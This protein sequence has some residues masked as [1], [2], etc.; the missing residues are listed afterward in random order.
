MQHYELI[1]HLITAFGGCPRLAVQNGCSLRY[2]SGQNASYEVDPACFLPLN[3]KSERTAIENYR[4]RISQIDDP[5]AI[6]I[7]ER[8]ILDEQNHIEIFNSFLSRI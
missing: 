3:I 1:G 4:E 7:L 2:W 6:K 8:I 5:S